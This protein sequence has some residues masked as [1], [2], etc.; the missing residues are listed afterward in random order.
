MRAGRSLFDSTIAVN[1]LLARPAATDDAVARARLADWVDSL[2]RGLGT[3]VG[4]HGRAI[5]GGQRQR[6]ALARVL[7]ADRPV[8]VLDEPTEHS[9]TPPPAPS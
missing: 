3:F 9:T 4:E 6:S 8:V 2:P 5:S 7:L 1:L